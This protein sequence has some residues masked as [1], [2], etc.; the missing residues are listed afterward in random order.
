MARCTQFLQIAWVSLAPRIHY[1]QSLQAV[2][3]AFHLVYKNHRFS[4]L[5]SLLLSFLGRYGIAYSLLGYCIRLG[6]FRATLISSTAYSLG[7]HHET[8]RDNRD[9]IQIEERRRLFWGL[10]FLDATYSLLMGRPPLISELDIDVELPSSISDEKITPTE[11]LPDDID[12]EQEEYIHT[13]LK[14]LAQEFRRIYEDLYSIKVSKGRTRTDLSDSIHV[15]EDYM[16]NWRALLPTQNRSFLSGQDPV[17]FGSAPP[18]QILFSIGYFYGLCLI[19]RP[20]L[21][22]TTRPLS[23]IWPEEVESSSV[24]TGSR[25]EGARPLKSVSEDCVTNARDLL[26]LIIDAPL[27]SYGHFP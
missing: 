9:F 3:A 12:E 15:L 19:R 26:N 13:Q 1:V 8:P 21:I 5:K 14:T 17:A 25:R 23:S 2:Q 24:A 27:Q 6:P 16:A 4:D 11:I 7:L 18:L 10:F 22:E 20:A